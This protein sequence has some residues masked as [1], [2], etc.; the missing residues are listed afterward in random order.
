MGNGRK[1]NDDNDDDNNNN[2][3]LLLLLLLLL[4]FDSV[5]FF[6]KP[7][8][9][10]S[11]ANYK[12]AM[13]KQAHRTN[14]Y[15]QNEGRNKATCTRIIYTIT[16]P[17]VQTRQHDGLR[18]NTKAS[19]FRGIAPRSPYVNRRFGRMYHLHLQGWKSSEEDSSVQ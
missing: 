4:Q 18:I 15:T 3:K 16:I 11:K 5:K 17:L 7:L 9:N 10:S 6:F 14:I 2:N 1:L 8:L 19:I 13:R 12:I